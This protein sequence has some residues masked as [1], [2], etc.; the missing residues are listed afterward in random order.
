MACALPALLQGT[1]AP[2]VEVDLWQLAGALAACG[3]VLLGAWCRARP[4]AR[5]ARDLALVALT[6]GFLVDQSSVV[7]WRDDGSVRIRQPLHTWNLAHYVPGTKYFAELGYFDLYLAYLLVDE[8]RPLGLAPTGQV[9]DL[10]AYRSMSRAQALA[11]AEARGVRARFSEARWAELQADSAVIFAHL[12]RAARRELVTDLGFN[13]SPAWL[14]LHEPLLQGVRLEDRGSL[15]L[16]AALQYPLV[17]AAVAAS[18][19]AFGWRSTCWM[20]LWCALF[21][22]NRDRLLG[23]YFSYDWAALAVLG[24]ALVEKGRGALA[25][26]LVAWAGLMRGF[27]GLVALGPVVRALWT[28]LPGRARDGRAWAFSLSLAV[29]MAAVLGLSL[30]V[31]SGG[32]EAWQDWAHKI[33]LH[34]ERISAGGRRVGLTTLFG[35]DY[36]AA[37]VTTDMAARRELVAARELPLRL[38][39]LT[40][41]GLLLVVLRRRG[42]LEG[43][44]LGLAGGFA[45]FVVSRY[46]FAAWMLWLLLGRSAAR[47][48][49]ALLPRLGLFGLVAAFCA[50][51]LWSGEGSQW[52]YQ[53]V[54]AWVLVLVLAV[55]LG[56]LW[57]DLRQD[58]EHPAT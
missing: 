3:L 44:V 35:E 2:P 52:H 49:G 1:V 38:A 43:Y 20:L 14:V 31:A 40:L 21:F 50:S 30:T 23:G 58:V 51:R 4:W 37:G 36:G 16:L 57:S 54:N 8:A 46:Y 33:A 6:V 17:G 10:R 41:L 25:A 19:W 48:E 7:R 53:L 18:T 56:Y 39:Q 9:R 5:R 12:S 28:A 45:L 13:P 34:S 24:A 22:G 15:E 47:P 29:S 27:V 32:A 26:P 11:E 55:L 42:P